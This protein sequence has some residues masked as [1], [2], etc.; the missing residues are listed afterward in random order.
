MNS[1]S[2]HHTHRLRTHLSG[3]VQHM[4]VRI[5]EREDHPRTVIQVLFQQRCGQV[6]LLTESGASPG[7][8]THDQPALN[9]YQ[10]LKHITNA[11]LIPIVLYIMA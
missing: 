2:N 11:T 6:L 7:D 10:P 9:I 5:I 4:G 8:Q 1:K 3:Q